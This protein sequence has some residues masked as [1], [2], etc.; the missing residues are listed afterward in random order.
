MSKRNGAFMRQTIPWDFT[1]DPICFM[2]GRYVRGQFRG[3]VIQAQTRQAT[4]LVRTA[5]NQV[6]NRAHQEVYQA[7]SDIT[8]KYRYVATLDNRTTMICASL[9]GREFRVLDG[10]QPNPKGV[11]H[12]AGKVPMF[13]TSKDVQVLDQFDQV[14]A[15]AKGP[16]GAQ[17][18]VVLLFL[19]VE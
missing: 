3:G 4:A 2:R 18:A 16:V 6:A 17:F 15:G 1:G 9:D 13:F 11:P 19:D 8:K 5:V 7:N 12:S 10:Q 14:Q